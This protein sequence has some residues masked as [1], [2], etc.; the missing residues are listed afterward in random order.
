[1]ATYMCRTR[2]TV[3]DQGHT[4]VQDGGNH[5]DTRVQDEVTTATDVC[6]VKVTMT[7]GWCNPD[8]I[9]VRDGVTVTTYVCG[10]A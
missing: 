1:M 5:S 7:T 8:D 4:R 9:H 10:M 6:R 2:V 3:C